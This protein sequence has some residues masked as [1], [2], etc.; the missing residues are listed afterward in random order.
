MLVPFASPPPAV[1]HWL[2]TSA[3]NDPASVRRFSK[4]RTI[5]SKS[6]SAGDNCTVGASTGV[7]FVS[8]WAGRC[9]VVKTVSNVA[10]S[11]TYRRIDRSPIVSFITQILDSNI[12]RSHLALQGSGT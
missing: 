1:S 4:F 6:F 11:I 12:S 7:W 9:P 3:V 8:V 5:S 10:E 2:T